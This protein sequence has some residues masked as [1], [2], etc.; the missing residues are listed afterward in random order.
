M[1]CKLNAEVYSSDYFLGRVKEISEYLDGRQTIIVDLSEMGNRLKLPTI[2][3]VIFNPPATI[4][5]WSD[6][7]KTVV[8]CQNEAFDREKGLAMAV[9]KKALGNKSNFNNEFKKWID[10]DSEPAP[11]TIPKNVLEELAAFVSEPKDWKRTN[12]I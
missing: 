4:V 2:K 7:T 8:K 10:Y 11:V 6:G 5:L 3:K 9:A 1:I 12:K